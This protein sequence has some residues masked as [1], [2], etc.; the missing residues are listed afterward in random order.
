MT[1]AS[2]CMLLILSKI[3]WNY[4]PKHL[5]HV[6]YIEIMA[7]F[8]VLGWIPQHTKNSH[9]FRILHILYPYISS[10]C[11]TSRLFIFVWILCTLFLLLQQCG[12]FNS[13]APGFFLQ[14]GNLTQF[15]WVSM[16]HL[17]R[18]V[19]ASFGWVVECDN[20]WLLFLDC[21]RPIRLAGISSFA[22][23]FPLG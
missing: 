8:L 6:Q 15:G 21:L 3:L 7:N 20:L 5:K 2:T 12:R 13:P 18:G 10:Q 17:T 23:Q 22:W 16:R 9:I 4:V 14:S 11:C 1:K 19:Y